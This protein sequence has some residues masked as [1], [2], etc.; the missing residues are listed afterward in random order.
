M[1]KITFLDQA[2]PT[3]KL[4]RAVANTCKIQGAISGRE[5]EI[6]GDQINIPL[7]TRAR[8]N[9]AIVF[10]MNSA[11]RFLDRIANPAILV[12]PYVPLPT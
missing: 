7:K 12:I 2:E 3:R 8:F 9:E 10:V 5:I 1:P 4:G 6:E 11:S